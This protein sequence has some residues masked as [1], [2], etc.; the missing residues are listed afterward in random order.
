MD[1][2]SCNIVIIVQHFFE[3]ILPSVVQMIENE[4]KNLPSMLVVVEIKSAFKFLIW[5]GNLL[6]CYLF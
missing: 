5:E 2:T 3:D 1:H 6:N 4:F